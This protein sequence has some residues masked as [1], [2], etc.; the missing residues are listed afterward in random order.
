MK[1]IHEGENITTG[2]VMRSPDQ[3]H[4][5]HHM[6][7][8]RKPRKGEGKGYIKEAKGNKAQV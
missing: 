4:A 1:R 3:V 7:T 2:S 6:D 8:Q 5:K